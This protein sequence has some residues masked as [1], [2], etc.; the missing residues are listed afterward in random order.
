MFRAS[1]RNDWLR[2]FKEDRYFR[3]PDRIVTERVQFLREI[4]E[5][6]NTDPVGDITSTTERRRLLP[7]ETKK[8]KVSPFIRLYF[9]SAMRRALSVHVPCTP[10]SVFRFT[11]LRTAYAFESVA[12]RLRLARA[13]SHD[14]DRSYDVTIS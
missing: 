1:G 11:T 9:C 2:A 5:T 12:A 3:K 6:N 4:D 8:V 14:S 10:L 13:M 7:D